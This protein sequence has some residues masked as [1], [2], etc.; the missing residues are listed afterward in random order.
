MYNKMVSLTL[1]YTS[2][3]W[4]YS[5]GEAVQISYWKINTNIKAMG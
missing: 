4:K 1:S 2:I 3:N 5:Y